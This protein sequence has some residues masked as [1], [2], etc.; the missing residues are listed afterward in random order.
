MRGY[1][2]PTRAFTLMEL[3]LVMAVMAISA[4]VVAP[5]LQGLLYGRRATEEGRRALALIQQARSEAVSSG[6]MIRVW[7]NMD[8][9]EYGF[10]SATETETTDART[11]SLAEG[12]AIELANTGQ[13]QGT[14]S[15]FCRPD[16][17]IDASQETEIRIHN[18]KR[19]DDAWV[20]AL[21]E[22]AERF[23][24]VKDYAP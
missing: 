14:W 10:E 17:T 5:N 12:L 24:L 15:F 3:V 1:A 22:D 9:D 16:G 7:F 11:R 2:A 18:A 20:L 23:E 13:S 21:D 4:A 19:E 8:D 6:D